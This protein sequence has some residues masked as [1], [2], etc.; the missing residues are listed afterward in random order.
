MAQNLHGKFGCEKNGSYR[1]ADA[2]VDAVSI[3]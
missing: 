1:F 3:N 2:S